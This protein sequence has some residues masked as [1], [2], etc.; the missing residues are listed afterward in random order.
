MGNSKES[1]P[2]ILGGDA[3]AAATPSPSRHAGLAIAKTAQS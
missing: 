1:L 2:V 3:P